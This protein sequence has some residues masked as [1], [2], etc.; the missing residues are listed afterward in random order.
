VNALATAVV[1]I[2]GF[3]EFS[4]DDDIDPDWAVKTMEWLSA[5]LKDCSDS[6]KTALRTA[7][8]VELELV[9]DSIKAMEFY[10]GLLTQLGL[11]E[12]K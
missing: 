3:L 11:E 4:N 2:F 5:D 10:E 8:T 1:H 9:R 7:I 12:D 6:E